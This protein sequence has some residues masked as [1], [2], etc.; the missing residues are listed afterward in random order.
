MSK[1]GTLKEGETEDYER[2]GLEKAVKKLSNRGRC[3]KD[4]PIQMDNPKK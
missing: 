2:M 1:K 3:I 4:K